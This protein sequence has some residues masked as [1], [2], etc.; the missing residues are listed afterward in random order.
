VVGVSEIIHQFFEHKGVVELF[1]KAPAKRPT[2]YGSNKKRT[3]F[4]K[5]RASSRLPGLMRVWVK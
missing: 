5:K 4:D 1:E 3:I 2:A